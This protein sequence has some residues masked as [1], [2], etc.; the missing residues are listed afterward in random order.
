MIYGEITWK[1]TSVL[2]RRLYRVELGKQFRILPDGFDV[3]LCSH[4]IEHV[5]S[6]QTLLEAFH[7]VLRPGGYLL[8]NVPINE[9]WDD[10][11]H[12][13]RYNANTLAEKMG[14][15]GFR[16]LD[17]WEEDRWT[18]FLLK[19]Q[20]YGRLG[21]LGRAGLR[22]FRAILAI[23]PLGLV[24]WSENVFLRTYPPQQLLILGSKADD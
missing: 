23:A 15:V 19:R 8:L 13:R 12:V 14:Q 20:V 17:S 2:G 9:V 11:R 16:I 6:D 7:R 21:P 10:P 1:T 3:I 24:R 4:V 22:T 5:D 18:A